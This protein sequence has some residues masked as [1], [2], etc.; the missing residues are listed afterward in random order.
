MAESSDTLIVNSFAAALW[1]CA[2]GFEPTHATADL[3]RGTVVF[4]FPASTKD[5]WLGF[6]ETK[7][8]LNQMSRGAK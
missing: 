2:K 4:V 6:H 8:R 1:L 5:A 7:N 3:T